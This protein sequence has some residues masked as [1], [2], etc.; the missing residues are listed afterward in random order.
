[1]IDGSVLQSAQKCFG[2]KSRVV[3]KMVVTLI[4]DKFHATYSD[5]HHSSPRKAQASTKIMGVEILITFN[6][7][8]LCESLLTSEGFT[9]YNLHSPF[10]LN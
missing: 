7:S 5:H 4:I 3:V 6:M 10:P 2:K 9:C 1:M 8:C